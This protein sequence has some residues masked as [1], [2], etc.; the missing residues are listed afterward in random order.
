[1]VRMKSLAVRPTR[2]FGIIRA[3][4]LAAGTR[5]GPY[6]IL[7]PLG[8]GGMGEVYR[9]KDSRL[10][11]EVAIKVLP[12]STGNDAEAPT[13]ADSSASC[14]APTE[15]LPFTMIR[16]ARKT[17]ISPRARPGGSVVHR[18]V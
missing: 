3:M 9:A 5:F 10:D 12:E 6:E 17:A 4:P 14:S 13:A 7:S 11:R 2:G 8:A 16:V 1:M 15:P 18:R